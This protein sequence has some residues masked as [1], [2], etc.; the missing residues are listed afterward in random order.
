MVLPQTEDL[1]NVRRSFWRDRAINDRASITSVEQLWK[2][3]G[4]G[5]RRLGAWDLKDGI[6]LFFRGQSNISYGVSNSLYRAV[7]ASK[8]GGERVSE[9]DLFRAEQA[10]I[11]LLR[12]EGL[13]RHMTDGQLL[14]LMQHHL[15]PTR[16][17]DVSRTPHEALYFAVE[18]A[19]DTDGLLFLINPH[20]PIERS[21]AK[22]H[23][24][25]S[26][27]WERYVRGT[28]QATK[29]W[30]NQVWLVDH[31]SLDARMHAQNGVFLAG[32]LARRYKGIRY[33][34]V[35]PGATGPVTG[36]IHA[37]VSSYSIN[38][39]RSVTAAPNTRWGASGWVVRIESGWKRP[40]RERLKRE[41]GIWFDSIY[42]P[43]DEV[44]RLVKHVIA[45]V[46]ASD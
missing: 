14:M 27:P 13:G 7:R 17:I 2:F 9:L 44:S 28:R 18:S 21:E 33:N 40:L 4:D 45:K 22:L 37:D 20:E 41:K 24:E 6:N 43:V 10:A 15:M 8:G 12:A 34:D 3:L 16:L 1:D 30:T 19:E 23:K 46:T 39:L 25:Q 35:R 36:E 5:K 38:W 11:E 42:P 32:G 31:L 29:D 26:L